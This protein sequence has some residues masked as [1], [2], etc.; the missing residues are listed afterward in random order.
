MTTMRGRCGPENERMARRPGMKKVK[1]SEREMHK[2]S[3]HVMERV[4][5]K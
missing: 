1:V 2:P 5:S 3:F 4:Y